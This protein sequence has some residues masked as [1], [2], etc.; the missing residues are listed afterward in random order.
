MGLRSLA[1]LLVTLCLVTGDDIY[2]PD[3]VTPRPTV[4]PPPS[5][6]SSV[7]KTSEDILLSLCPPK[8]DRPIQSSGKDILLVSTLDGYITALDLTKDGEM[9]WSVPTVPGAML[10]STLSDLELDDRGHLVRLIPSLSGKIYKLKEEMVEPMAMDASSLLSSSLKMQENLV[11]TGGKETRTVG[12]DLETGEV[13]YECGMAGDCHQYGVSSDSLKNI[14]VVQRVLHTVKA[15]LPRSGENKWNFSVSLHDINYFPGVNLC[16]DVKVEPP[17]DKIREREDIQL[18]AVVPEGVLCASKND[19]NEDILWRRKFQTPLVDVWRIRGNNI[20]HVDMFS[21]NTVPKRSVLVDDDD[22]ISDDDA[23]ELYIGIHNKQL[24]IQESILMHRNT[25]DAIKDY[26]L[27]PEQS[28][29]SMPRVKWKPYLVSPSRTPYYDHGAERPH[30]PLLI[31]EQH[32]LQGDTVT[33]LAIM[34]NS[35]QYPYDSGYYLYSNKEETRNVTEEYLDRA[36]E[37]V[38]VV[39]YVY[40]NMWYWWK[41]IFMISI[42]TAVMM[43][44]L[45]TRPII[46]RMRDNFQQRSREMAEQFLKKQQS[47]EIIKETVIEKVVEI[48]VQVPTFPQTPSTNSE[49]SFP[50]DKSDLSRQTSGFTSRFLSDF[51]PVQCLG[52]GG[53]GVVFECKNNYDDIHYAVKRITLPTSEEN[54]KKVKRE[55]KLHA[56]LDHKNVVR[57]FSTWEETPPPGWQRDNDAWFADVE[58]GS[59]APTGDQSHTDL[60]FSLSRDPEVKVNKPSKNLNPLNPFEGP[61]SMSGLSISQNTESS[62]GVSFEHSSSDYN[63]VPATCDK[64]RDRTHAVDFSAESEGSSGNESDN[65]ESDD[66]DD[67]IIEESTGGIVFDSVA[68]DMFEGSGNESDDENS[69]DEDSDEGASSL[70]CVE[71]LQWESQSRAR[72]TTLQTE[73]QKS[74]MYIVMQLC[75][76]ET[77]RD[78]LR[79]NT[80][81]N[82]NKVFDIFSQI[83]SGVEYVHSHNLVHRDLKPSNIYF[84]VEGVIK[85]GDFGLVTDDKLGQAEDLADHDHFQHL[86]HHHHHHHQHTDQVGTQTYMSPEQLQGRPY[87]HKVDIYSMGLVLLELLVPFS[88]QVRHHSSD[89][90]D[91]NCHSHQ[92]ERLLK[93]NEAKKGLL[94]AGL[95]EQERSLVRRLLHK[96]PDCRPESGHILAIP[97]LEDII[98]RQERRPRLNTLTSVD[99]MDEEILDN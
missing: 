55:V 36:L 22:D 82:K 35:A 50:S 19:N 12:I 27:N 44:V 96:E 65:E 90:P 39:E 43:N 93:F 97:W 30:S 67:V 23:P 81:R 20:E 88:T 26:I 79:L 60:S 87:N 1:L 78:W 53:F 41:E 40:T 10:S 69:D 15:H 4:T 73:K 85:I 14:I 51:Q 71:A 98:T 76:K 24:Y 92:M 57:Y 58:L 33:A 52:R 3:H 95:L 56:K 80:Q 61:N 18:K 37:E 49:P 17:E 45:I 21:K 31:A 64:E 42:L 59:V 83:C 63:E 70:S 28:Q 7:H 5:S 16:E 32:T 91:N 46:W 38:T 9:V 11:L 48:P 2:Y 13:Q 29:L 86:Q 34:E 8:L 62:F 72:N 66:R 68:V 6:P 47:L 99:I 77:L 75:L 25:E 74:F 89:G 94:P 54:R 84:S